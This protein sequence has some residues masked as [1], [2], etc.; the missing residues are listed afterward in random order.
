MKKYKG[1]EEAA[2]SP[3]FPTTQLWNLFV[4]C[5]YHEIFN[6]SP[7]VRGEQFLTGLAALASN[8]QDVRCTHG[9][10]SGAVSCSWLQKLIENEETEDIMNGSVNVASFIKLSAETE[11]IV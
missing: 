7:L 8:Y 6:T 11:L 5:P 1:G 3:A 2:S 10:P 9:E 4:T